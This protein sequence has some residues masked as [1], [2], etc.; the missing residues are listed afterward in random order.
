MTDTAVLDAPPETTTRKRKARTPKVSKPRK[1]TPRTYAVERGFD[2]EGGITGYTD[3]TPVLSK[4]DGE[5]WIKDKGED[6]TRYRIVC[7][8]RECTVQAETIVKRK[9]T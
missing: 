5:R 3:T 9:L 7:V 4:A 2:L 8:L 6:G 1:V